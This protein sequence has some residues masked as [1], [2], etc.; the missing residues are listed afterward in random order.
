MQ[1]CLTSSTVTVDCGDV[2]D[3]ALLNVTVVAS[4]VNLNGQLDLLWVRTV[5]QLLKHSV[6]SRHLHNERELALGSN[7]RRGLSLCVTSR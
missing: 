6:V 2:K 4:L 1:L 5:L 7:A 3:F